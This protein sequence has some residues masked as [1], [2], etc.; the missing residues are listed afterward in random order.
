MINKDQEKPEAFEVEELDDKALENVA[1]GVADAELAPVDADVYCPEKNTNC[2]G[3][4]CIAGC[5]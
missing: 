2:A 5:T 4:N 1:G 3:A